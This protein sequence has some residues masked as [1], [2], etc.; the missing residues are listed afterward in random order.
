[1]VP[2]CEGR[3]IAALAEENDASPLGNEPTMSENGPAET[4]DADRVQPVK[5]CRL[6]A[7]IQESEPRWGVMIDGELVVDFYGF[8]RRWLSSA[9]AVHAGRRILAERGMR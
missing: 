2:S 4:N 5:L 9:N 3:D 6:R 7:A 8:G 1:M